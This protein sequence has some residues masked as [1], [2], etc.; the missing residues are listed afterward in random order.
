MTQT[1]P[2]LAPDLLERIAQA[3]ER[4]A[5]AAPPRPDYEAADAFVWS[6]DGTLTP[7]PHVNRV[8]IAL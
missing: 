8:D 6:S 1:L 7:V 4:L 2:A 3:L 5:P